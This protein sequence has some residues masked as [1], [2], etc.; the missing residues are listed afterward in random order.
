MYSFALMLNATTLKEWLLLSTSL[1]VTLLS[2]D[3]G[4]HMQ[5]S[6]NVLQKA[7]DSRKVE[8]ADIV[9]DVETVASDSNIENHSKG[10][11]LLCISNCQSAD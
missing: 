3:K 7:I 11:C 6:I 4:R 8:V 2:A 10:T 5:C 9:A 1:L